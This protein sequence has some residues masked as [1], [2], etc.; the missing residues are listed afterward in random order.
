[1]QNKNTKQNIKRDTCDLRLESFDP[2]RSRGFVA[3]FAMLIATV[4]L[5]M[6]ISI[7]GTA[8]KETL[9]SG[10]ARESERAFYAADTGVECGLYI[11]RVAGG[12]FVAGGA[13]EITCGDVDATVSVDGLGSVYSYDLVVDTNACAKVQV[14]KNLLIDGTSYTQV[15][16]RGYNASC[17][18]LDDIGARRVVERKLDVKYKNP[19]IFVPAGGGDGA[20]TDET[21][22][23]GEVL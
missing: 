9:L 15:V 1:M 17:D 4:V 18:V 20:P 21:G 7:T 2:S 12:V 10:S 13:T 3:V 19:V 11:D 22:T 16:S 5:I 6:V 23:G 14:F 8:Y